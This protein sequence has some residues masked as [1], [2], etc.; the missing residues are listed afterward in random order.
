MDPVAL[1]GIVVA[2]AML[3]MMAVG[4][5]QLRVEQEKCAVMEDYIQ[6]LEICNRQLE[7]EYVASCD[8]EAV[9]KTALALGMIP[10][11]Q[12]TCTTI[13]VEPV[14]A[15]EQVTLWSRIGTFL[16]GLFA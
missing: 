5:S 1:L 2:V 3:L 15:Q 4:V 11:E 13:T 10:A 16:T 7:E 12:A 6:R 9:E 14:Q 8:L